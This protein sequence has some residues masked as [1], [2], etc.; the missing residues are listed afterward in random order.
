MNRSPH[1][2]QR[3]AGKAFPF[4]RAVPDFAS[5]HPGYVRPFL[6]IR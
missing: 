6:N 4:A 5:L 1:G 2:A 3:N